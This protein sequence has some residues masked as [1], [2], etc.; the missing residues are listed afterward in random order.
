MT[1]EVYNKLIEKLE[2]AKKE[3]G[4]NSE[5]YQFILHLTKE[6]LNIRMNKQV[7]L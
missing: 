7:G 5:A 2:E 6:L 3:Y 1:V 4:E